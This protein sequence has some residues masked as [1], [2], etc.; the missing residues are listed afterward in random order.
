MSAAFFKSK[1]HGTYSEDVVVTGGLAVLVV[2]AV[3]EVSLLVVVLE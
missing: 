2:V 1:E 3:N